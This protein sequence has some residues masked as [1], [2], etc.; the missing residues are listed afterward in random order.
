MIEVLRLDHRIHRDPRISTHLAL[1]SRAFGASKIYY[2]G[3]KDSGMEETVNKIT[4]EFGGPFSIEHIKDE[5]KF[6]K[7]KKK[8]N[9]IVHLTVYGLKVQEEIK[10]IKK[11]DNILVI[12]GGSKV[13]GEIY[14]LA[15]FNIA[16]TQQPHSELAALT[17]FLDKYFDSKELDKKF[18]NPKSIVMPQKQGKLVKKL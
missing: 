2:S 3:D 4:D 7:E 1:I 13:P 5:F 8:N 9:K 6:I 10:N 15:D 17:I 14:G 11:F 16:V 18:S 12:V